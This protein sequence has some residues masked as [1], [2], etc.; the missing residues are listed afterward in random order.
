M[1]NVLLRAAVLL[2][3]VAAVS[4]C[5]PAQPG[6]MVADVKPETVIDD[7]N[8]LKRAIKYGELKDCRAEFP[9][10]DDAFATSSLIQ[11][12][13]LS[14]QQ[15]TIKGESDAPLSLDVLLLQEDVPPF[16]ASFTVSH[17]I[18]YTVRDAAGQTVFDSAVNSTHT[19]EFS[20]SIVG[21]VRARLA[22]EGSVKKNITEFIRQLVEKS[23]TEPDAFRSPLIGAIRMYHG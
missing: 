10:P 13:T 17:A 9:I 7:S 1:L 11:A 5:T 6:A 14:L 23:R 19:T 16:G 12:L 3:M 22:V 20:E 18:R 4:A 21:A 8:P 15:H 2:G